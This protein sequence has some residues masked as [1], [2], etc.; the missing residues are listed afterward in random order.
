[1]MS[2]LC[3]NLEYCYGI[4][5]LC[6]EFDFE[7]GETSIIYAPNGSMKSSFARVFKDLSKSELSK[8]LMF[9]ERNSKREVL[10]CDSDRES[11]RKIEAEEVLVIEPYVENY[12]LDEMST[13]LAKPDLRQKYAEIHKEIATKQD[14]ALKALIKNTGYSK[15]KNDQKEKIYNKL[16]KSFGEKDLKELFEKILESID[17]YNEHELRDIEYKQIFNSE[18]ET[19][20][21]NEKFRSHISDYVTLYEK[22]I[23][24]S[25]YLSKDFNDYNANQIQKQLDNNGFFKSGHK[26]KMKNKEELIDNQE[27]LKS[28]IEEEKE[29]IF[30]DDELKNKFIE[31]ENLLNKKE[32]R[33]FR[34]YLQNNQKLIPY[35]ENLDSLEKTLWMIYA[36]EAK[37]ELEDFSKSYSKGKDELL[38]IVREAKE[39]KTTWMEAMKTFNE[40]FTHL[41]FS[42]SPINK[43]DCIL[44]EEEPNIQF[45]FKENDEL[46]RNVEKED[47]LKVLSQ[48]ETR[49]L[50]LLHIIFEIEIRKCKKQNTFIIIDDIADSFDY[51]NK[52]AIIEYLQD[53]SKD[54]NFKQIILTHNYDFYRTTK[55]RLAIPKKLCF[56]VYKGNKE[57]KLLGDII[58][59]NPIVEIINDIYSAEDGEFN[60]INLIASIPILRNISEYLGLQ[61]FKNQLTYM[62]HI[63][64]GKDSIIG[65]YD[66]TVGDLTKIYN[67]VNRGSIEYPMDRE[68]KILD[69]I[70]K[71]ADDFLSDKKETLSLENKIVLAMAIRLKAEEKMIS[72]L[73]EFDSSFNI[74]SSPKQTRDLS[75][76][77]QKLLEKEREKSI[78]ERVR[79]M[80]PENIHINSFMYEPILDMADVELK[81]LYTQVN[82]ILGEN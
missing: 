30:N 63:K 57:I 61:E 55:S 53:I 10:V 39:S 29:K 3:V 45:V 19:L 58:G 21:K 46:Q 66:I 31:F 50:Y 80:T 5:K 62:L 23:D 17:K 4:K 49:A 69:L 16:L 73:K 70:Y 59:Q 25:Q 35:L 67:V 20:L 48:G 26:L 51:K 72:D 79:V 77:Y 24:Q 40:R 9:P 8:D 60:D 64:A 42:L 43:E 18:S 68:E 34:D 6:H 7:G 28:L 32:D 65:T 41:P 11:G 37:S 13:L 74:P 2:K 36:S 14:I 15:A 47:L 22:L 44:H 33:R 27:Q 78:L 54:Q 12:E 81:H 75:K 56:Q 71:V 52:Y 76:K 1:M 38:K 82:D